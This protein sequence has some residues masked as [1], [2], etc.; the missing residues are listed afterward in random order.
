MR[1]LKI[2]KDH[3]YQAI[4]DLNQVELPAVFRGYPELRVQGMDWERF[5]KTVLLCPTGALSGVASAHVGSRVDGANCHAES[6]GEEAGGVVRLDMGRCLFCGECQVRHPGNITF[7]SEHRMACFTAE[8]LVVCSSTFSPVFSSESS[9]VAASDFL[10]VE[11]VTQECA[12]RL[13]MIRSMFRNSFKLRELCAGGDGACEMELNATGNV[14]FDF[15]RDG[16]EFVASPRHA[17][18]LVITGPMT[19]NMARQAENVLASMPRPAVI[20]A[21]GSDA[22]SGGLFADSEAVDRSFFARHAVDLYVPGNPAH[23]LTF[24]DGVRRLLGIDTK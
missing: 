12:V 22:I 4:R 23:P 24:I 16:V 9:C 5:A 13:E 15:A 10:P 18:G 7:T 11:G 17:D 3:G 2:F 19:V 20:I 21:V 6:C 14:N 1:Q 8:E